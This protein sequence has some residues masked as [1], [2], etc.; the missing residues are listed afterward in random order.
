MVLVP[1]QPHFADL[2]LSDI[3]N[4]GLFDMEHTRASAGWRQELQDFKD[5]QNGISQGHVPETEE[6]GISSLVFNRGDRPFHPKRLLAILNGFGN[7]AS[8]V[9]PPADTAERKKGPFQGV[10][11]AK[12][13]LWIASAHAYPVDFHV[14]GRHIRMAPSGMPWM[15][16][17]PEVREQVE[18][19]RQAGLWPSDDYGDRKT[20]A[21]FIGVGLDKDALRAALEARASARPKLN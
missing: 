14:A 19:M 11:R 9:M 18:M 12:G 5:A 16:A 1:K 17:H 21:V 2:K 8:S 20:Q 4:T 15:A 13:T 7:Y 3:C 10:V 6:Y